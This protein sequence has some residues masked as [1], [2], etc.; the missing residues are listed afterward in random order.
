[1]NKNSTVKHEMNMAAAKVVCEITGHQPNDFFCDTTK[2]EGVHARAASVAKQI[3]LL[4]W[5]PEVSFKEGI[6]KTI[7]WYMET[8]SKE[9]ASN[10]INHNL[11]NR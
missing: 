8:H 1:M 3:E 9:D 5:K 2:P 6:K 7:E 10:A 11:F 4:G